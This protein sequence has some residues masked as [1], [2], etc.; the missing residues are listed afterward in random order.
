MCIE[1]EGKPTEKERRE[2]GIER[3]RD[4]RVKMYIYIERESGIE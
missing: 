3:K 4:G 1:R 2:T